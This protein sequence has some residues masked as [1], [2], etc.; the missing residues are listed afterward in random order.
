MRGVRVGALQGCKPGAHW[1]GSSHGAGWHKKMSTFYVPTRP[2]RLKS[3]SQLC[4]APTLTPLMCA[5]PSHTCRLLMRLTLFEPNT[6]PFNNIPTGRV[7]TN[8]TADQLVTTCSGGMLL[9]GKGL[10]SSNVKRIN[11][12]HVW[13]EGAHMRGVRIGV[14]HGCEPGS[15]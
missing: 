1:A 10:G 6:S 3:D 14:L 15:Q 5:P 7:V 12:L 8:W 2:A 9:K 11:N 13:P 4:R